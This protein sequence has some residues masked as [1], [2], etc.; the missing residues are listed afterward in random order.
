MANSEV[1]EKLSILE[2]NCAEADKKITS[3][4]KENKSLKEQ[5]KKKGTECAY[6]HNAS[7]F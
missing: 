4:E 5:L 2:K 3:L 1:T 6:Y 7:T